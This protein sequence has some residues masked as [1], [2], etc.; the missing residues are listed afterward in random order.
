MIIG[1][2]GRV[3]SGKSTLTR[4]FRTV[5]NTCIIYADVVAH[6]IMMPGGSTYQPLIRLLG[7]EILAIDGTI[8][9]KKMAD[10]MYKS[11]AMV[12]QVNQI[13]HPLVHQEIVKRIHDYENDHQNELF[14]C[15]I[16]A[17]LLYEGGFCDMCDEVWVVVTPEE[18]IKKRLLESR[19]YSYDKTDAILNQQMTNEEFLKIGHRMFYNDG[20]SQLLEKQFKEVMNEIECQYNK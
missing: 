9:R 11:A 13:V 2:T 1:I 15:V 20:D 3:G 5:E 10:E 4:L 8:D 6:D 16:E 12:Q 18:L 7:D 17:A 14:F 19:Q